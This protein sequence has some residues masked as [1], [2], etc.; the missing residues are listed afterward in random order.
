MRSSLPFLG[1]LL[2]HI[3]LGV[4][5][6]RAMVSKEQKRKK[7]R[8]A[9]GGVGGGDLEGNCKEEKRKKF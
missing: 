7:F 6:W 5:T 3:Y 8:R 2:L 9:R 1:F 4:W